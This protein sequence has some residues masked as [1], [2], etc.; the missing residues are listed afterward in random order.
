MKAR[1][2]ISLDTWLFIGL[3]KIIENLYAKFSFGLRSLHLTF[4][5]LLQPMKGVI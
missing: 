2:W 1:H 5:T 3:S 4:L